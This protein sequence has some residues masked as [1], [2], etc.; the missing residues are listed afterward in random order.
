MIGSLR[1]TV[2]ERRVITETAVE[3]VVDVGGVGYRVTASPRAAE[4][5]RGIEGEVVFSIHTHVREGGITLYGFCDAEE[6]RCFELLLSA[7]GVGPALALSVVAVHR[8]S[9]LSRIVI[10]GEVD[11]LTLVPGVGRKTAER[12]IVDLRNRFS[13]LDG[14]LG[15]TGTALAPRSGARADVTEALSQLGYGHEEIRGAL[16]VLPVDKDSGE[17]LRLALRE[18]SPQ[19]HRGEP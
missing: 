17:L 5:S 10:D 18:L 7:H 13:D 11:S 14:P 2:T 4:A 1:G 19:R 9:V 12:L 8:P 16:A 6:R 3:L 15:D